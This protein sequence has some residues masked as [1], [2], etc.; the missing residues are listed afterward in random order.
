M[1]LP[2]K[3]IGYARRLNSALSG[4]KTSIPAELDNLQRIV[5]RMRGPVG[6][7]SPATL[8]SLRQAINR[9]DAA[10][11]DVEGVIDAIQDEM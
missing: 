1:V 9:I 10:I 2:V 5:D 11:N 7:C 4:A 6:S 3:L 8:V